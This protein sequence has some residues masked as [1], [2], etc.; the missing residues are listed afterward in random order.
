MT[1]TQ[2]T[3]IEMEAGGLPPPPPVPPPILRDRP[4]DP[5]RLD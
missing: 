3:V 2:T 4:P 1:L 5:G